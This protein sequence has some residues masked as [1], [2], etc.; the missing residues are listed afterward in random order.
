MSFEAL[1]KM[2]KFKDTIKSVRKVMVLLINV[3]RNNPDICDYFL[4]FNSK[5][6]F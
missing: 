4:N 5:S 2:K 6:K 1:E 3:Q